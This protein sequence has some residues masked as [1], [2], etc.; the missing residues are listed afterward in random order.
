MSLVDAGAISW[1]APSP[2][3]LLRPKARAGTLTCATVYCV[4]ADAEDERAVS[5]P[6][7]WVLTSYPIFPSGAREGLANL[8]KGSFL[9]LF[10]FLERSTVVVNL[11]D[12]E[13][14]V[15]PSAR[16]FGEGSL[17]DADT[18]PVSDESGVEGRDFRSLP[19]A[20]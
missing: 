7:C 4:R 20:K 5:T 18:A 15:M 13:A 11:V 12:D 16:S 1:G 6:A 2:R 9:E 14:P 8:I 19:P 17:L 3:L 10:R